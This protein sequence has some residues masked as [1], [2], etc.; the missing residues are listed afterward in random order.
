[1]KDKWQ[2]LKPRE[3][4]IVLCLAPVLVIFI[5]YSFIW[6]PLNESLVKNET[7]LVRQQ[8]LLTWV[9]ENTERFK[10]S[11]VG[12][13]KKSSKG[14]ASSIASRTSKQY[15][16]TLSRIQ[17]QG[18]GVQVWVDEVPFT[19]LLQWL[20]QLSSQEGLSVINI[21]LSVTDK[22]GVVQVRRLQLG[23]I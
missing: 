8:A 13:A 3:Q 9:K 22:S 17:A 7:K 1:M 20:E 10:A 4:K 15:Q 2:Q 5:L 11:S 6:Q 18:N 19:S 14:S 21:D 23:K 12:S 16:I